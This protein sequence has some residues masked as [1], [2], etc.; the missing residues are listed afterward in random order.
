MVYSRNL[1]KTKKV[2]TRKGK[3]A[4]TT[5]SSSVK[6]YVKKALHV[7]A[8]NKQCDPITYSNLAI[9]PMTSL[10]FGTYITLSDVWLTGQGVEQGNRVGNLI[11]PVKWS[12][13]GALF[14][15]PNTTI[16]MLVRMYIFKMVSGYQL[17][18]YGGALPTDFFQSGSFTNS[19]NNTI[20][21]NF[22]TVNK[23]KYKVYKSQIFKVGVSSTANYQNNDFKILNLFKY[24]LLKY[25]NHKIKFNDNNSL[26]ENAGLYMGFT[27][28]DM[29]DSPI[30]SSSLRI[31]YELSGEY[32][33]I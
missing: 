12:I 27:A 17:P 6:A 13:K 20:S 11:T 2:T 3:K 5:V 25:Q 15:A 10:G 14:C 33:D 21:D 23:D 29:D 28:C 9:I 16:P 8:E 22:K 18:S 30:T 31:A 19:P 32:E 24:D 1:K 26:P 7:Q 4:K